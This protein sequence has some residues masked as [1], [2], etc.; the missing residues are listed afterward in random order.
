MTTATEIAVSSHKP[1]NAGSPW[2]LEEASKGSPLEAS[3]GL[4]PDN[5]L[6]LAP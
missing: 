6:M 2:Q 3:V 5:T 4:S 1:R